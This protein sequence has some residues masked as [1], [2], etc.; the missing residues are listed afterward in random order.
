MNKH[1]PSDR[2]NQA[3]SSSTL[4][5]GN[6]MSINLVE[7]AARQMPY[8][9]AISK[10]EA[11][12]NA[13]EGPLRVTVKD[14]IPHLGVRTWT[15]FFKEHCFGDDLDILPREKERPKLLNITFH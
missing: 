2:E 14:G 8:K 6:L 3:A 4:T 13:T 1:L 5:K 11:L 10:L 12:G 9:D 15:Q 7:I